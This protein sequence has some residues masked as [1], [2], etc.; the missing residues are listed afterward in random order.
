[1]LEDKGQL[2]EGGDG[3]SEDDEGG[4]EKLVPVEDGNAAHLG[5]T[6]SRTPVPT[7]SRSQPRR[8]LIS[9]LDGSEP[10]T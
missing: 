9:E 5:P 6:S 8:L 3:A 1:M 10:A 2:K 4:E 7:S